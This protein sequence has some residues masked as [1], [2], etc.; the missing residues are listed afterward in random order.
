MHYPVY[1]ETTAAT[2][3]YQVVRQFARMLRLQARLLDNDGNHVDAEALRT[4]ATRS[5]RSVSWAM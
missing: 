2:I 3:D 1:D 5:E 4:R